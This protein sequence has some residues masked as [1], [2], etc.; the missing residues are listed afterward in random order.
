MMRPNLKSMS[1]AAVVLLY[2]LFICSAAASLFLGIRVQAFSSEFSQ[3]SFEERTVPAFITEKLRENDRSGAVYT[4]DF[5]GSS[6]L[7]IESSFE[8]VL[9]T[10]IIYSYDGWLYELFCEKGAA[11]TRGDGTRLVTL[12]AVN[13][14]EPRA[15]LFQ[16]SFTESDGK[17]AI[18]NVFLRNG[19]ET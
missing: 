17:A 7:F 15:G 13:F 2:L 18:F 14:T 4:G 16:V 12:D 9:Y 10:D 3:L 11:F 1:A 19:G 8:G 5:N 6:A